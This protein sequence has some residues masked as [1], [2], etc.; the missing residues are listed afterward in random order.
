MAARQISQNLRNSQK[1]VSNTIQGPESLAPVVTGLALL[2]LSVVT[3]EASLNSICL[4]P[5]D[6]LF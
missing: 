2:A 4:T 3:S 1:S 5:R 6:L